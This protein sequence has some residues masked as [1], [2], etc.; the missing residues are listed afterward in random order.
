MIIFIAIYLIALCCYF[1]TR[2][3]GNIKHRAINKYFMATM[4]LSL[5]FV[6]FL[7]KYEFASY[8]TLLLAALILAWL[9][10]IFLVFDFNRGGDFFLAGNICFILY[11]QAVLIDKGY[12]F[13]DFAWTYVVAGLMLAV[14]IFASGRWPQKIK[15]GKMRWPMIF[16]LSSIFMHGI[17][18]LALMIMLPDTNYAMLGLGSFL[19][20]ISD[21]DLNVYRFIFNDN[22][23]LI[24]LNSLTYFV[25][26]LLIVLSTVYV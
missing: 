5:A 1:K 10:D 26:L 17:T 19:F 3:S 24:R 6:T 22:K 16:Y 23:W 8:Q 7:D 20:M 9:G 2:T 11:E 13:N 15:M 18:G 12:W 4:Y 21:I 25:G 14:V